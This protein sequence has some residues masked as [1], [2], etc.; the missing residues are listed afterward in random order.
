MRRFII[1]FGAHGAFSH[2]TNGHAQNIELKD[3]HYERKFDN[4]FALKL[5]KFLCWDSKYMYLHNVLNYF[6]SFRLL[7]WILLEHSNALVIL[8]DLLLV[9]H[10]SQSDDKRKKE[11]DSVYEA[12]NAVFLF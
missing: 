10:P 8:V 2:S 5:R 6:S 3:F 1:I 12:A 9:F 7:L 11:E 4:K